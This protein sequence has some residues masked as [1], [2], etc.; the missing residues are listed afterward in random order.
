MRH[1]TE[2][3]MNQIKGIQE[4]RRAVTRKLQEEANDHPG[5]TDTFQ[6]LQEPPGSLRKLSRK[7]IT[8]K[9]PTGSSFVA[10][11]YRGKTL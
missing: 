1:A 11:I 2:V 10:G 7:R 8:G 9:A 6:P 3:P 5:K 4:A